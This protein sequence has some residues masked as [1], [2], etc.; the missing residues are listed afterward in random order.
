MKLEKLNR[1]L[2]FKVSLSVISILMTLLALE[3]LL[4][5]A[6]YTYRQTH[7]RSYL[8]PYK[9]NLE[10]DRDRTY[11]KYLGS[12]QQKRRT[13]LC[14][15]DSFTNAG[16]VESYHSYPYHLFK[17]FE[18]ISSPKNILNMGMC[19]NSTFGVWDRLKN[20]LNDPGNQEDLPAAVVVL[21]GSADKFER[22][23]MTIETGKNNN[24][25]VETL[26]K[27]WFYSLR[28]YKLFRHFKLALTYRFITQGIEKERSQEKDVEILL[29][30]HQ[31]LKKGLSGTIAGFEM[32]S[33]LQKIYQQEYSRLSKR[34][35][36]Y[37][38][39]LKVNISSPDSLMQASL[40]YVVKNYTTKLRHDVGLG[41]LLE[42]ARDL[43]QYFWSKSFEESYFYTLQIFQIQSK[44][45]ASDIL[46]ILNS[47][48]E[49][50]PSVV[51]FEYFKEFYELVS[52]WEEVSLNVD[53]ARLLA[54]EKIVVLC[55]EKKVK[56][57]VMNYP[58][59]YR[60]ANSII[61][62]IANKFK[63]PL[64]D[65]NKNFSKLVKQ[66]G[67]AKYLDDDDHF[68]PLGYQLMAKDVFSILSPLLGESK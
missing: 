43:P 5:L 24:P 32:E 13:I 18:K 7:D 10:L 15:G 52:N 44:F 25:W 68:T 38:R 48:K 40:I 9:E 6:G 64:V 3:G 23:Q 37:S 66:H 63:L 53:R 16:N 58:S 47:T 34:F 2:S 60:S 51:D 57:V 39:D 65:N 22:S 26:P 21:V 54:W 19:E 62:Q 35:L 8:T 31:K 11:E 49:H 17:H 33:K 42:M 36:K 50:R 56:L 28:L 41:L 45:S 1:S 20:Y 67:R 4:R 27:A 55:R 30:I 46:K 29:S 59:D 12:G 61:Y 14:I